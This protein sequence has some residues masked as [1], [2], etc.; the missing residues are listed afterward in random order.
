MSP[1]QCGAREKNGTT[2]THSGIAQTA[3]AHIVRQVVPSDCPKARDN[4]E[5]LFPADFHHIACQEFRGRDG[6]RRAYVATAELYGIDADLVG[7]QGPI[8]KLLKQ[9]MPCRFF[10]V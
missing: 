3:L 5:N 4:L 1:C 2:H 7:L 6:R 9:S 10:L 8:G